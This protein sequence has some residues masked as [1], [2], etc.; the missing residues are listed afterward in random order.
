M[1]TFARKFD[2]M[3]REHGSTVDAHEVLAEDVRSTP[4]FCE[5]QG[6]VISPLELRLF[7]LCHASELLRAQPS[8]AKVNATGWH[9]PR[10]STLG[11][12]SLSDFLLNHNKPRHKTREAAHVA[13]HPDS[14]VFVDVGAFCG[15]L[16]SAGAESAFA[17]QA[18]P[19]SASCGHFS[20]L[21]VRRHR[22]SWH[23]SQTDGTSSTPRTA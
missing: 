2:S 3:A 9:R 13:A 21:H 23:W 16:S 12:S 10:P 14:K 22:C 4:S 6:D 17:A 5:R 18:L 20:V 15:V 11:F 19:T 7:T 1:A 8:N